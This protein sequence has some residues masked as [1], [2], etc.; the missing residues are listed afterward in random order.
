MA[1]VM[2]LVLVL[3][4]WWVMLSCRESEYG[5]ATVGRLRLLSY[6]CFGSS[7]HGELAHCTSIL[8][9]V[10]GS[11]GDVNAEEI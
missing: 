6:V 7:S 11:V 8:G 10:V 5:L 1:L 3:G 4:N 2:A 9:R